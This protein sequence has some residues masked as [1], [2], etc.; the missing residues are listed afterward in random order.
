MNAWYNA[1]LAW[2][3]C[4][5]REMPW[6]GHPDAYAVW[7][8]EIM[9]QQTQV[10]TVRPYFTRFLAAFPTVAALAAAEDAPLLKAW[11]GLGYYTRVRNLRKAAQRL[12]AESSGEIPQTAEALRKLPGIGPYTAAAI[13]SICFNEAVPVVD[14]N[15]ARVF[16]RRNL[17]TDDFTKEPNRRKLAAWL[18]PFINQVA[19]P[20]DFNQAMME[21]GALICTPRNPQ[22]HSCPLRP[23][24]QAA[25]QEVQADYPI[26]PKRKP[27]PERH[28]DVVLLQERTGAIL[29]KRHADE[30]LLAG[31]WELPDLGTLPFNIENPKPCGTHRQTFSH[32]RQILTLFTATLPDSLPPL[33]DNYQWCTQPDSLPLTTATRKILATH[34]SGKLL[35]HQKGR[36]K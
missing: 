4:A 26:I 1:L 35:S 2:Y 3:H 33:P 8:S 12:M 13:A 27:L 14:G 7:V 21:L 6:R 32:F 23:Q 11:E 5:K 10:D 25:K 28:A 19:A 15:V 36:K 31:F 30:R 18:Q 24:C 20:G 16:A 22:C 29:F 9:L 34:I 17:L